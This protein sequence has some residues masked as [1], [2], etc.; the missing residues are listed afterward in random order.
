MLLAPN[1]ESAASV[2]RVVSRKLRSSGFLMANTKDRY[3]WTEGFH[4][5]R[6]GYGNKV[7]L[8]YHTTSYNIGHESF[9]RKM[10]VWPKAIAFLS[11]VGYIFD[12]GS[13]IICE[14]E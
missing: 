14:G 12:S 11:E 2:A 9:K 4:V 1:I 3:N 10:E 5:S 6:V 13:Y 7:S 8:D